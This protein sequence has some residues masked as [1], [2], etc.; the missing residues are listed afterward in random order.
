[1]S[2]KLQRI[3]KLIDSVPEECLGLFS[4]RIKAILDEPSKGDCPRCDRP[5]KECRC[6]NLRG[7]MFRGD[8]DSSAITKKAVELFAERVL[9][10]VEFVNLSKH[11]LPWY[12][13]I[14][15]GIE[16]ELTVDWDKWARKELN[17][18]SSRSSGEECT[19]TSNTMVCSGVKCINRSKHRPKEDG[20]DYLREAARESKKP[21][22]KLPS[23]RIREIAELQADKDSLAGDVTPPTQLIQNAILDFLD[24]E[25]G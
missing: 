21:T 1:M 25:L 3:R 7:K 6:A 4:L 9:G 10:N 13:R 12:E 11:K 5:E 16:E 19:C 17:T 8:T 18:P 2:D 23:E 20:L 14:R 24:E 22:H 15:Q